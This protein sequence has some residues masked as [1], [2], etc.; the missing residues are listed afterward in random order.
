[1]AR[2]N[3]PHPKRQPH[4]ATMPHPPNPKP[5]YARLRG[6][7][8]PRH[9]AGLAVWAPF[10]GLWRHARAATPTHTTLHK[11]FGP[12]HVV[13]VANISLPP[14]PPGHTPRGF[15]APRGPGAARGWYCGHP[16]RALQGHVGAAR[17]RHIHIS[18]SLWPTPCSGNG[19][20]SLPPPGRI[21]YVAPR[22]E[23]R[24]SCVAGGVGTSPCPPRPCG[25]SHAKAHISQ[26]P[27]P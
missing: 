11:D 24:A 16:P 3:G 17:Q 18:Q 12:H 14:P 2:H 13:G 5:H 21:F 19:H 27:Q 6:P 22:P 4:A 9:R 23:A 26:N 20:N 10:C 25:G 15:E 1:M 8:G 7:T